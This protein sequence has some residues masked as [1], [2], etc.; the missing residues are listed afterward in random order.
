M[1]FTDAIS[2]RVP[3]EYVVGDQRFASTRTDVLVY[4]TDV[5]EDDVT[6]LVVGAR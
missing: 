1:P 3:Q 4:Q 2:T 5:L 6:V